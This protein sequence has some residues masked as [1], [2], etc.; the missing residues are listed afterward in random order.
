LTTL[1]HF[2]EMGKNRRRK[3]DF[4]HPAGENKVQ[5]EA[6]FISQPS[7]ARPGTYPK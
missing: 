2:E 4:I 5:I 3:G 7:L 1:S 6:F